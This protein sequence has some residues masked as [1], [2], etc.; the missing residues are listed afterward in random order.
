MNSSPSSFLAGAACTAAA[1]LLYQSCII[2]VGDKLFTKS[3]GPSCGSSAKISGDQSTSSKQ[4]T[5]PADGAA[6][7]ATC[8]DSPDL[9]QRIIR[10]AEGAICKRTSRLIIVV[11]RCTNDHNYSAILR[12]AEA[13]GVQNI[14]IISPQTINATL[15]LDNTQ[16]TDESNIDKIAENAT[17]RRSSGPIVRAATDT[18][19]K[20]RAMHHLYARKATEWLT[21]RDFEDTKTCIESLREEGYQIWATDL[22]QEASC[23]TEDGIRQHL[24][25]GTYD[26]GKLIPNKVAIV[27]GTEAVGCTTEM[28]NAADLRVYL[29]LRGFADSLNLSVATAL[30]VHQ[31]FV[32]DPSLEGAMTEEERRELRQAWYA[33]LASQRLLSSADKKRRG[34]LTAYLEGCA[35]IEKKMKAGEVVYKE[36]REKW[37]KMDAKRAEL[38]AI[39][40]KLAADSKKAVKELV[41]NPP[42][43]ITDMRRADEHRIC[44]V[45]KNTKKASPWQDMPATRKIAVT[46]YATAAFFR[47]RV[48]T[49]E[50][51]KD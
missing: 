8:F 30:V 1:L 22:G 16:G 27:F 47:E 4:T 40:E 15:E 14:W 11:E 49:N 36:E 37:S 41:D 7:E 20:D 43:P 34:K 9:D 23:L 39:E 42:S 50:E 32:L 17:M 6:A 26:G 10:K 3:G 48:A 25:G 46:K 35:A 31:M 51:K 38:N 44:F 18:E 5:K 33:K 29:P 28:L 12:T 19:K 21:V 2:L 13:L 24:G 45:G